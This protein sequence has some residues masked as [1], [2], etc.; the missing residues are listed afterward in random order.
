MQQMY[1][2]NL[3]KVNKILLIVLGVSFVLNSIATN[4]L[5]IPLVNILGLSFSSFTSG[6]I[7][8]IITYPFANVGLMEVI[9]S[10]LLLWFLGSELESIW[11]ERKYLAYLIMTI[12]FSGIAYLI[13][14]VALGGTVKGYPF[15]GMNVLSSA[16][17]VSY[18]VLF[19]DRIFQFFMLIPLKAK[20]FCMILAGMSLYSGLFTP[21]G[22]MAFGNL[23]AMGFGFLFLKVEHIKSFKK[24]TSK[25]YSS[26]TVKNKANLRI[27]E[28]EEKKPPRYFQ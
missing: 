3:S 26:K 10:G 15:H 5:H 27:V 9:F 13:F 6:F 22:A 23:F 21:N 20:Y 8:Q 11:G 7:F 4:M 14:S 16:M 28:D 24:F 18:A 19:P 25:N 17:C 1:M 2:P 12:L